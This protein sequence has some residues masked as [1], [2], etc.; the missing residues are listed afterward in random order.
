MSGTGYIGVFLTPDTG[1]PEV[2]INITN[3]T[4]VM[5]SQEEVSIIDERKQSSV[6]LTMNNVVVSEGEIST[7]VYEMS[8]DNTTFY[9]I[10]RKRVSLTTGENDNIIFRYSPVPWKVTGLTLYF[11]AYFLNADNQL[12]QVGASGTPGDVGKYYGIPTPTGMGWIAT[13]GGFN[14]K[15]DLTEFPAVTNLRALNSNDIDGGTWGTPATLPTS[16]IVRLSW[17]DMTRASTTSGNHPFADGITSQVV[18][19]TQW[20][21]TVGYVVFLHLPADNAT[22]GP[23][24]AYPKNDVT[25]SAKGTWYKVIDTTDNV[26][27]ITVPR[28]KKVAFYVACKIANVT[29]ATSELTYLTTV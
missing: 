10:G 27:E 1:V 6:V 23:H 4:P 2:K 24:Y 19:E 16:G 17:D 28:N 8:A 15:N 22:A 7:V 26:V 29:S 18:T 25:S 3:L 21:Q 13:S 14:G 12:A 9:E 20:R 5:T 11:R